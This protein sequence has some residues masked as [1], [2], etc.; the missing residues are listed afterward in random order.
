MTDTEQIIEV[1]SET[2][3]KKRKSRATGKKR[4]IVVPPHGT[5]ARYDWKLGRC[6]CKE[7]REANRIWQRE[8]RAS[9]KQGTKRYRPVAI[10]G[11]RAKYVSGCRC[12]PC[13]K[14]N[15]DYQREKA[16]AYRA[17]LTSS[18]M[19]PDDLTNLD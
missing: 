17:G 15:R 8:Y 19:M 9:K 18:D 12:E 13:T 16:K 5:R 14:A 10:H 3:P 11:T 7:C 6:R 4:K 2:P 1:G